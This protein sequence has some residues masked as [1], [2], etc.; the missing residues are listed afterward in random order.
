MAGA[1]PVRRK[2]RRVWRAW[3]TDEN[4]R[5]RSRCFADKATAVEVARKRERE[6]VM[7]REGLMNPHERGWADAGKRPIAEHVE[8]YR[9]TLV[10]KGGTQRHANHTARVLGSLFADAAVP[11]LSELDP[12]RLQQ[13]LGRK[14]VASS[15]RTANHA[16]QALKAFCRWLMASHRLKEVPLGVSTL[17][18][19]NEA[20]GRKRVRRALTEDECTRLIAAARAGQPFRCRGPNKARPRPEYLV[21]GEERAILYELALGTGFRANE[22]RHLTGQDFLLAPESPRIVC[23]ASYSK[24]RRDDHQPIAERLAGILRPFLAGKPPGEPVFRLPWDLAEMLR[25]DL[26]SADIPVETA[27]GIIDVH[28]LRHTF[29]SRLVSRGASVK[30]AQTLARHSTPELTIGRYAHAGE[31]EVREALE[32]E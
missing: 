4:G 12:V 11:R 23:R 28:G 21:T 2:S 31:G 17:K 29:I 6:C 19:Y 8:D 14:H 30:V 3:W 24:H 18:P 1:F 13:A 22:L 20:V 32:K 5:R 9:L 10:A 15:P 27:D 7:I 16:M 26:A 25:V